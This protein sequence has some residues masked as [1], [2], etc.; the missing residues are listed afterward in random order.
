MMQKCAKFA[1][2]DTLK[3]NKC[4]IVTVVNNVLIF[5]GHPPT[6]GSVANTLSFDFLVWKS[7]YDILWIFWKKDSHWTMQLPYFSRYN[8]HLLTVLI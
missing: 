8:G 1:C 5:L 6:T 2:A 3:G 4:L 7:V